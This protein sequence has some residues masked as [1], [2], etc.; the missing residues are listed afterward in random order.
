MHRREFLAAGVG[1]T[2]ALSGC[3]RILPAE[4]VGLELV[5][6]ANL[7]ETSAH[8]VRFRLADRDGVVY[9]GSHHLDRLS[10][11]V[12]PSVAL[13]DELPDEPRQYVARAWLDGDDRPSEL[14]VA[15]DAR[16]DCAVLHVLV[17]DVGL[18]LST[19]DQCEQTSTPDPS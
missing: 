16:T 9:D 5:E 8:D 11:T 15:E 14:D 6:I 18:G 1:G 19:L 13:R 4:T 12:A 3:S 2:A 17:F 7:D 10:G